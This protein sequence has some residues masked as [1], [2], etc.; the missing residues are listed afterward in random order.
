M[1]K[2]LQVMQKE[3]CLLGIQNLLIKASNQLRTTNPAEVEWKLSTEQIQ[4]GGRRTQSDIEAQ[5]FLI[6]LGDMLT[7]EDVASVIDELSNEDRVKFSNRADTLQDEETKSAITIMRG[8]FDLPEGYKPVSDQDP[9]FKKA[10]VFFSIYGRLT[11]SLRL[12]SD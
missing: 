5:K 2:F 6:D 4:A 12:Q 9:N 1:R 10:Q 3:L 11:R 8:K 7:I